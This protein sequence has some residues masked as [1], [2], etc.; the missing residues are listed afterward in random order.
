M[1]QFHTGG[2]RGLLAEVIDACR[3]LDRLDHAAQKLTAL[4][5][6][7]THTARACAAET[8]GSGQPGWAPASLRTAR[9]R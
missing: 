2:I 5:I 1:R 7:Q 9:C 8:P 4:T 3:H 6:P